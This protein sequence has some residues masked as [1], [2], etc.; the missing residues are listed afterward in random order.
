M[1]NPELQDDYIEETYE[2][3]T[4]DNFKASLPQIALNTISSPMPRHRPQGGSSNKRDLLVSPEAVSLTSASRY[5]T[6]AV[7]RH[8][9]QTSPSKP[10]TALRTHGLGANQ[11][12][13][14]TRRDLSPLPGASTREAHIRAGNNLFIGT[15]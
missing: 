12:G 14:T 2:C 6:Q 10:S 5:A 15:S 1:R 4:G 3:S 13:K 11:P 7:A 9:L 8:T